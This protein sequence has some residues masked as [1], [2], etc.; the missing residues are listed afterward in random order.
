MVDYH[1]HIL[2][3]M[4]DGS[5]GSEDSIRMLTALQEQGVDTVCPDSSFL[6]SRGVPGPLFGAAAG[7]F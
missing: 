6:R 7:V 4:D 1:T 5:R 2:P 3:H